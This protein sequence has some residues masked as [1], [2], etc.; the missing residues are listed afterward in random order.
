MRW[1]VTALF[2]SALHEM[3]A[4]AIAA[5]GHRVTSHEGWRKFEKNHPE[6]RRTASQYDLLKQYSQT[7]RY[8]LEVHSDQDFAKLRERVI[9][10]KNAWRGKTMKRVTPAGLPHD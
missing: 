5:Y 7:A 6:L 1:A 2:Y 8:Y 10:I 4:Y 9:T 3:R